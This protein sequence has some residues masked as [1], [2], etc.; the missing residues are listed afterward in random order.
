MRR[1]SES[2]GAVGCAEELLLAHGGAE[3]GDVGGVFVEALGVGKTLEAEAVHPH[4][5]DY[6]RNVA[7]HR[8]QF[9]LC[10]HHEYGI[11]D[12]VGKHWCQPNEVALF[13]IAARIEVRE[14][15]EEAHQHCEDVV[16]RHGKQTAHKGGGGPA[17]FALEHI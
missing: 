3:G 12:A 14:R 15:I 5:E 6:E 9:V 1:W 7:E 13:A 16:S 11:V 8:E 10:T 2:H 17:V 4:A